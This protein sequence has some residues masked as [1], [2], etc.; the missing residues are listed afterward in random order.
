MPHEHRC[1]RCRALLAKNDGN[2]VEVR[3]QNLRIRMSGP[4]ATAEIDCYRCGDVNVIA[5]D[6]C[7]AKPAK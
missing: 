3:R 1:Q 6:S 4:G 7:G 5:C 2:A